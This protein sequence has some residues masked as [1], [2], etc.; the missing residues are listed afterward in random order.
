MHGSGP[1]RAAW[2]RWRDK[3][4]IKLREGNKEK[5]QGRGRRRGR[6]VFACRRRCG[7]RTPLRRSTWELESELHQET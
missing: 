1:G 4:S 3:A 6:F 2:M 5:E 7:T